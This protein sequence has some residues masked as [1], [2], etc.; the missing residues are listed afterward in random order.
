LPNAKIEK[1]KTQTNKNTKNKIKAK[2]YKWK[3]ISESPLFG[4]A[5]IRRKLSQKLEYKNK[6]LIV[7]TIVEI[8]FTKLITKKEKK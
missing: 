5:A 8:D 1:K 7:Q 4:F 2:T 3:I 6:I